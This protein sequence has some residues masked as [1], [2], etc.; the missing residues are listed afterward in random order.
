MIFDNPVNTT[1]KSKETCAQTVIKVTGIQAFRLWFGFYFCDF[2]ANVSWTISL[3]KLPGST[4]IGSIR[5]HQHMSIAKEQAYSVRC[6]YQPKNAFL[7]FEEVAPNDC[8]CQTICFCSVGAVRIMWHRNSERPLTPQ[9]K[10]GR[11]I[12]LRKHSCFLY[13]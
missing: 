12:A 5:F 9:H 6:E 1:T 11:N 7:K 10:G 2:R 3:D 8:N 4:P 13:I